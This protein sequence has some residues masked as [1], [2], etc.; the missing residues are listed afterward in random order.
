MLRLIKDKREQ[1]ALL[2]PILS[3]LLTYAAQAPQ[4]PQWL[5]GVLDVLR[6]QSEILRWALVHQRIPADRFAALVVLGQGSS[7]VTATVRRKAKELKYL[8]ESTT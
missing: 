8:V 5:N 6:E 1:S 7:H 4:Q 2:W 3:H